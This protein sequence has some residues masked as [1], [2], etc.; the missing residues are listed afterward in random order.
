M[1][2]R[3]P[4]TLLGL[5]LIFI[6]VACTGVNGNTGSQFVRGSG[7]TGEENRSVSNMTA[8]ELGTPGAMDITIGSSESLRIEA[9]DNL[10]QYIQTD[11]SGGRL[12]IKT[13]PGITLQ[14]VQPIKYHLTIIR[15]KS[16]G[17][18]SSGDM[19]V[20]DLK[21]EAFSI[22]ISSSGNLSMQKLDC[23]S[24][25]VKISSSGDTSISA[26]NAQSLSVNISSS[27]NLDIG[28]GTVPKQIITISSSGEYRASD[29]ASESADVRLSSSGEATVRVS[30]VLTG[31]LSSSGNINYIGSPKVNV[32]MSSSGK[33]KQ[34]H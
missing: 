20:P 16:L 6:S 3:K 23:N 14:P 24:L 27:G 1:K 17:I 22:A 21:S 18:S 15:L 29:L 4:F 30:G 2:N 34:T 26:L 13:R 11:V 7:T 9:D 32:S 28:G 25:Q 12:V 10:L 5:A 8:V 33:P 31:R 19:T